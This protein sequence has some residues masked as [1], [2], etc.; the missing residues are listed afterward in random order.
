MLLSIKLITNSVS[1]NTE[2]RSLNFP[3][4]PLTAIVGTVGSGKSSL[5]SSMLGDMEKT[6]GF[7]NV[8]GKVAYVP[9]V[10]WMQNTTL[11]NNILFGQEAEN[12]KYQAI[13]DSCALR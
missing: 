6:S 1:S 9:Q 8:K 5:I 10:A 7:V 12:K 11:E 13:V 3:S 2:F 4:R